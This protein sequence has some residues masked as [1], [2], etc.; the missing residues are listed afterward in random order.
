MRLFFT[1]Q[2]PKLPLSKMVVSSFSAAALSAALALMP[3]AQPPEILVVAL[4][5]G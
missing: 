2:S 5:P 1:V 3:I 4:V